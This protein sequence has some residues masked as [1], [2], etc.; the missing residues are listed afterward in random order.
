[1]TPERKPDLKQRVIHAANEALD[2]H[3]YVSLIDV[4][5]GIQYLHVNHVEYWKKGGLDFLE[6]MMQGSPKK[7]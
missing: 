7:S 2:D 5:M 4:L 1:M 6:R 3:Q